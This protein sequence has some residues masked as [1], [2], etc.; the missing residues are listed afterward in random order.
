MSKYFTIFFFI[1]YANNSNNSF[2]WE[3]FS[4]IRM[5][6]MIMNENILVK[7]LKKLESFNKKILAITSQKK[8]GN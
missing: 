3:D 8:A 4:R 7:Y 5:M 1:A 6:M 2:N